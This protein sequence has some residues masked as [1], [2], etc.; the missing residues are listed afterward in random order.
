MVRTEIFFKRGG[1]IMQQKFK[2][3]NS[4]TFSETSFFFTGNWVCIDIISL[5][6]YNYSEVLV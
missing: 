3:V 5:E 6:E 4:V 2:I 1:V